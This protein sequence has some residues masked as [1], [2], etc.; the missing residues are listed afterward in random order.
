[1]APQR[2]AKSVQ[3]V[4]L[5][6]VERA[7]YAGSDS[8]K[9]CHADEYDGWR[10]SPM[11]G[12]TRL[13]P[14]AEVH[15]PFDGTA[16]RF[17]DDVVRL[18]KQPD[19]ARMVRVESKTN[20]THVFRV[21]KVIGGHHREDFAG[22][23]VGAAAEHEVVLPVSYLLNAKRLRYK[24]YSVMIRERPFVARGAVWNQTCI[25]CHNTSPYLL[26]M[27]GALAGPRPPA[28]QGE[29]VDRILPDDRRWAFEVT[30]A[31]GLRRALGR[32]V[33]TLGGSLDVHG[34]DRQVVE[35]T[36]V[37]TRAGFKQTHLLEVG[38]GCES[39]HGGSREHVQDSRVL[40]A[41]EPRGSFFRVKSAKGVSSRAEQ[42]N[43]ACAR[44]HQV[45]FS[46][47]PFTWEG[48]ERHSRPGGSNIN[49]GEARDMLL[50]A[51]ARELSCA[52]CHDPHASDGRAR[53]EELEHGAANAVCTK[54]HANLR[55]AAAQKNHTHH[56]PAGAAGSCMACHMPKKNMSLEGGL[57]RYHRIG[58]PTDPMRVLLDRPLECALC[59]RDKSVESIVSDMERLW[60]KSYDKQALRNLYGDLS[61]NVMT[62]TLARGKPHEQA[63]ALFTLG[64]GK[65]PAS[66]PL[67]AGHLS[68]PYPLVREYAKDALAAILGTPC[69]VDLDADAARIEESARKC[70]VGAGLPPSMVTPVPMSAG[71]RGSP[72]MH[73]GKD[74]E[75]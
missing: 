72:P 60:N 34:S 32:E 39:C 23:E 61:A 20:G 54:C 63:V 17:K 5:S 45:L 12:M 38:I 53:M 50:G 41:F 67:V 18:Q 44:C 56:D 51:C 47:Y 19:G 40:P 9:T 62:A 24:G 73:D 75:D 1:M 35:R 70:L 14:G 71:A 10:K 4:L 3:G 31:S 69:D 29:L 46:R 6:N 11:H 59:H 49:S 8:C 42:I 2:A 33:S 27:L 22:V 15:A 28:Y 68:H 30:D 66:A 36:M 25:F 26:S 57:T 43:H 21:T 13:V 48:G 16:F 58:S 74:E 52:A 65:A 37:A 7:D 64:A 55:E